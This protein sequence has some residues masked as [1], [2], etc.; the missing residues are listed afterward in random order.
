MMDATL[1]LN[2]QT[3]SV[4]MAFSMAELIATRL[5]APSAAPPIMPGLTGSRLLSCRGRKCG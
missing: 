1:P 4:K 3:L 5:R 2:I